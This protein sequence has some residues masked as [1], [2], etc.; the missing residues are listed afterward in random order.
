MV[1]EEKGVSLLR[2]AVSAIMLTMLLTSML[3]L[4]FNVQLVKADPLEIIIDTEV[5]ESRFTTS[6]PRQSPYY[7]VHVQDHDVFHTRAYAGNFWYTLCGAEGTGEPLYYGQWQASLPYSG[8]YEV[9]VWI[10]NP[11]PFEYGGRV[12]TPTQ[13]A[14]YQIYHR[15]GMTTRTVNQRLRTGSWYSVGTFTFGATA[16]II[17]NDRTG[18]P[19]LSTMIAFDAIK[20]VHVNNPPYTPSNPS[21]SNH[22][23]GVSIYAYLSWSGGDPDA[24][25]TVTYDVYFGVSPSPPLVSSGQSATTYDPGILSYGTKYYWK[26]VAKDNYGAST[27]G[28]IWDFTTQ[29]APNQP[30]TLYNGYVSPSSGDTST[31]FSYYVTYSDPEGDVPTTKYVYIDGSPYTMAKISGDYVS[32]AV[33]R[34]STTLSAG[35]HNFYF[36]FEDA[37]HGHTKRL[38]TP[39]TYSGP[40]VSPPPTPDF[41]ISASPTS[42]TIQQGSSGSSTI[43]VTSINGFNQ[44]VQLSVS[45]APSGVT[46]TLSPSQVTPPAGGTATSTLTVSVA[47]TATPGSYTLTVTGTSG[48]LAHSTYITLEITT[49]PPPPNNP[50]NTPSNPT[51]SNH[52]TGVSIYADLSWSGGDPD[53]G[54]TVTYDVYFGI[55]SPPPLVSNDQLADTYDPGTLSYNTKYY[56]KIVATDNHGSSSEG[57]V[58]DFTT[59]SAPQVTAAIDELLLNLIDQHANSYFNP[60]WDITIDQYKAWIATIASGEG[61]KG[62]YVAH[63][64]GLLGSDVFN[65]RVVGSNFRFSTGI[66]PF[67]LDRGGGPD[68]WHYWPTI[69]KL[70]PEEAVK[71]VLG[72]HYHTFGAGVNLKYFADNSVW[73]AVKGGNAAN[74]WE[75][76]TGASWDIHNKGKVSL[77]WLSIKNQLSQNAQDLKFRYETNVKDMGVMRWSIRES[78]GIKTDTGKKV[79]FDGDYQTWLITARNWNGIELFQYYYT[80]DQSRGIE[81]WAWNNFQ[82]PGNKFRY[83]FVREYTTGCFPEHRDTLLGV[84]G[85][86]LTSPAIVGDEV[87]AKSPVD[88]IVTDPEGLTITKNVSEV[89]GMFYNEFDMDGDGDLDDVVTILHRKLGNYSIWVVPEPEAIPTDTF[90]LEVSTQTQII[91]LAENVAISEIPSEPYIFEY[92]SMLYTFSIVWGEETFIVPVESN[93]TVSNF[94]FSQPDKEISFYVTGDVDTIGFCNVTIPKALLYGEPWTVLIDGA[95]VSPTITENATHTFLYFTYTH[96]THTIQIIGTWVIGPPP[97]ITPPLIQTPFQQPEPDKVMPDQA[98]T[99]YVNVT[100]MGSG[101]KS[102]ILSYTMNGGATWNNLTMLYNATTALYQATIPAFPSGTNIC[103]KVIAY[104][105]ANNVAINDNAGQYYCYTVNPPAPPPLSVSINPLSASILVGQSVTFTST[106]SGGYTPYSYQWYLNGNPVSGATSASWT[107]APTSSGIYYLHLKVIDDKANTAQSET[108]R[109]TVAT[110]PVGGYSIPIQGPA[111]VKPITPYLILTAILTIAFTAIKRKTTRKTKQ[112]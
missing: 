78:D 36:Y 63:S 105:N 79:V 30:F 2:K 65:H 52:A 74:H 92:T 1:V 108:A 87:I 83:I 53:A 18:E 75:A 47:T 37:V 98:V 62:G 86:T 91:V 103:Y 88:L 66:G 35:T 3:M 102:V 34:Y 110:V 7:W 93:S 21:P 84:A 25:D 56:W 89:P 104:D 58:W 69:K 9:F 80:F 55:T 51:P 57:P 70:N 68:N 26:I 90:T 16:S 22:A 15:D 24:G 109:I 72:W 12:Y 6:P 100:D 46:A 106:V 10:P 33:F 40:T 31:T 45:G 82:D 61:G 5:G 8:R 99:V 4:A 23:T 14:I 29:S 97:D 49:A 41:S 59:E 95:S 48:A 50:P 43:T 38:P 60:A 73:F 94:A 67:Q 28:P 96:S 77:D 19:Y 64:Q 107:F 85:E 112:Q 32:G 81:V 71:S 111:T 76:V 20:F 101:V 11:D 27:T 39:G 54:D 13:S 44:P 17:L 42:L